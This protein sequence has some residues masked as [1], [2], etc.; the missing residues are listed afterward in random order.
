MSGQAEVL[1]GGKLATSRT[2]ANLWCPTSLVTCPS[3][4]AGGVS[5][6]P[7]FK[8]LWKNLAT[9]HHLSNLQRMS[10]DLRGWQFD[11]VP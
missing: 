1:G 7:N 5:V 9:N 8:N 2:R 4:K 11:L 10:S 3:P 6:S